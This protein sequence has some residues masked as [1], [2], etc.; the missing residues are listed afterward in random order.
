VPNSEVISGAVTNWTHRDKY[1]RVEIPVGV[2]YGSDVQQVMATLKACLDDHPDILRWPEPYVLF[3]GFGESSLDFEARGYVANVERRLRISSELCQAIERA[4]RET[5]IEIPF[6]QRDLHIR[7]AEGLTLRA[8]SPT[9]TP[10]PAP[11]QST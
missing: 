9:G 7:S 11:D 3:R 2:A 5:G 8:T 10:S 4:L 1:G 6:P